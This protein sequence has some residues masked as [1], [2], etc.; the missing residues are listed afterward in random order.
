MDFGSLLPL[1]SS[2]LVPCWRLACASSQ[3]DFFGAHK[4]RKVYQHVHNMELILSYVGSFVLSL[5]ERESMPVSH[6]SHGIYVDEVLALFVYCF[7]MFF[8]VMFLGAC[9]GP[10]FDDVGVVWRSP[11]GTSSI[12]FHFG[13]FSQ[14]CCFLLIFRGSDDYHVQQPHQGP[15][16][17]TFA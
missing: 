12:W 17:A 9:P 14:G 1:N 15:S 13:I 16:K 3:S 7:V 2:H 6:V 11:W 5:L 4:T 8:L 10:M